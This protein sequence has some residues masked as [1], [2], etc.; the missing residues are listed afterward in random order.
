MAK[1]MCMTWDRKANHLDQ[2]MFYPDHLNDV[3]EHALTTKQRVIYV[4]KK[5]GDTEM[6]AIV[7]DENCHDI[8]PMEAGAEFV[9]YVV[10]PL[11]RTQTSLHSGKMRPIQ[12]IFV[13]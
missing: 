5:Y 7:T 4:W 12:R 8:L 13:L 3:F 9:L 10:D 2:W 1:W 11:A 6:C